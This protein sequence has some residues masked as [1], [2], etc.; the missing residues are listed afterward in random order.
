MSKNILDYVMESPENTNPAVLRSLL[1]K[2]N[3]QPDWNQNDETAADYIKNRPFYTGD[4]VEM[5]MLPETTITITAGRE[6]LISSS[7][8]YSFEIGKTYVITFDGVDTEYTAYE[9]KGLVV[10]GYDYSSVAGGSGYVV[11]DGNGAI[12]LLTLD[13]SFVGSHTIAIKGYTQ[14]I[15]KIDAKYLPSD[16]APYKVPIVINED[17]R[18]AS[19]EEKKAIYD[20]F[21][22]GNLI[23]LRYS[24]AYSGDEYAILTYVYFEESSFETLFKFTYLAGEYLYYYDSQVDPSISST[25]ISDTGI[26]KIVDFRVKYILQNDPLNYFVLNSSTAGSTK[27]FK[28]TVDDSGTISATEVT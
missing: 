1:D 22:S 7:F 3:V 17:I 26:K 24:G 16:N 12:A 2:E 18:N 9:V 11:M 10:I 19:N 13:T 27:K 5:V 14:E 15:I 20:A 4:T 28:I 21:R 23:L 8:P 25:Q 6:N